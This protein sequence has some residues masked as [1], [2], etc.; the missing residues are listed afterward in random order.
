MPT[1]RS[2][3]SAL[4]ALAALVPFAAA[5]DGPA[6]DEKQQAA[7]RFW[8]A[9]ERL[10]Q[11]GRFKDAAIEFDHAFDEQPLPDFAYNAAQAYDKAGLRIE[12]VT[13][14]TRYLGLPKRD[15][16]DDA[17]VK[18]RIA[19]IT[20]ELSTAASPRHNALPY[21]EPATKQV[22]QTYLVIEDKEYVLI[23]VGARK[24]AGFKVYAMGLYVEDLAAR[25]AF[26]ALVG[27]AGGADPASLGR[28]ELAPQFVVQGDFAKHAVLRFVRDVTAKQQRESYREAL[29][30]DVGPKASAEMRRDAESFLA[31]FDRDLKAGG[32]LVIH[33]D[34]DG[35]VSLAMDGAPAKAGPKNLRLEYD[36][37]NIWLGE[38]PISSDLKK[39][40]IERIDGLAR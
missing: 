18:A 2:M 23:G 27:K 6:T 20:R 33:T 39:A 26:P 3:L 35:K 37:W 21:T 14:Y 38:K 1:G 10:F 8:D 16:K 12:A 22:F 11:Q 29:G 30:D 34:P 31:L 17:S 7:K 28:G 5:A 24:V 19:V 40:L 25:R 9:G 4:L 32:E 15:P 36:I 13:S